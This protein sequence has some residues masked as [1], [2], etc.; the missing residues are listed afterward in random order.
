MPL[1]R[2]FAHELFIFGSCSRLQSLDRLLPR[3]PLSCRRDRDGRITLG[4]LHAYAAFADAYMRLHPGRDS[5][6]MLAGLASL[7]MWRAMRDDAGR[8]EFVD[9]AM[10]LLTNGHEVAEPE[11]CEGPCV[12]RRALKALHV[13]FDVEVRHRRW[14]C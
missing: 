8:E 13:L 7:S 9:W 3:F 2:G 1:R 6:Y 14:L 5:C 11:G 4:E 12:H 10:Q